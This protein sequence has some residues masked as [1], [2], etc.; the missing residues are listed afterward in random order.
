MPWW[1]K[2]V[3]A[4]CHALESLARLWHK[5]PPLSGQT[6]SELEAACSLLFGPCKARL[7][8][9]SAAVQ[10]GEAGHAADDLH[11][12]CHVQILTGMGLLAGLLHEGRPQQAVAAFAASTA[13]PSALLPWL[14][15]VS[16]ALPLTLAS[17]ESGEQRPFVLGSPMLA[18]LRMLG[19]RRSGQCAQC[20]RL[21]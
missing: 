21:M 12:A 7:H 20:T 9:L 17:N 1:G 4:A 11:E 3:D 6:T 5:G 16:Q 2:Q 8:S 19:L 14:A 15:A 13:A 10:S 18:L